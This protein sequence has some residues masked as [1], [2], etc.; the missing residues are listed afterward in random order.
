MA[1]GYTVVHNLERPTDSQTD[2]HRRTHDDNTPWPRGNKNKNNV[3]LSVR[4]CS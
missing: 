3:I 2:R 1:E 4:H